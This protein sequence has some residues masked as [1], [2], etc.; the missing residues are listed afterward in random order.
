MEYADGG[1]LSQYIDDQSQQGVSWPTP[2]QA[3][4]VHAYISNYHQLYLMASCWRLFVASTQIDGLPED[5]VRWLFQQL[6]VALDYCHR[7]GI[8][9]RDVKVRA[10]VGCSWVQRIK[11]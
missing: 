11:W 6:I 1:D 8:A 9:N 4:S 3:A 7:L 10:G 5:D 2:S